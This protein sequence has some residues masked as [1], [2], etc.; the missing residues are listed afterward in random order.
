MKGAGCSS[1]PLFMSEKMS[2]WAKAQSHAVHPLPLL[3]AGIVD[4]GAKVI[5]DGNMHRAFKGNAG[6][7]AIDP[8]NLAQWGVNPVHA[9]RH[10][11]TD[12]GKA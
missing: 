6:D 5:N 3:I 12:T 10:P 8:C 1:R 4:I 11:I 7:L 9:D 2:V